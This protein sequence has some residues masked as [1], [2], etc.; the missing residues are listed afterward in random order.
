[1]TNKEISRALKLIAAL[2]ELHNENPFKLKSFTNAAFNVDRAGDTLAGKP[3]EE[4][5]LIPGIG[6]SIALQIIELLETGSTEDLRNYAAITPTGVIEMLGVKGIGPKKVATIWRELGIESPG[7]LLYA[8]YENRL[9][10]LK[11]FGTKTQ[12][13]IRTALEYRLA[14]QGKLHFAEAEIVANE[15]INLLNILDENLSISFT[16]EL[17]RYMEVIENL[18]LLIVSNPKYVE[19]LLEK[20]EQVQIESVLEE[21]ILIKMADKYSVCLICCEEDQYEREQL[22]RTGPAEHL[23]ELDI[24]PEEPIGS[25]KVFY[26]D[27]GFPFILP[28]LRDLPMETSSKIDITQLVQWNSIRGILHNHSTY[29]DGI[30]SLEEMAIACRDL[31]MEY[32]GICDHSKSAFYAGGL[33][34]E[35]VLQQHAEIE[36]LNAQLAPFKILKGIESDILSDGSLDYPDEILE[37]FDLVVASVHSILNMDIDRATKRLITAIENPYTTILGHPTGRLLLSR[38]G[39]PIDYKKVIDA[40]A[41]NDVIMELNAHPYRLD[42]DWRWIP[43]CMEK[44]VQISINPDAHKKEG[45]SDMH[46]GVY[47]A[48]KGG[49]TNDFLFNGKPLNEMITYLNNF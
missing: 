8:C 35:K 19:S 1:M 14:N 48:R 39:Y 9:V 10:D 38:K 21:S 6:K 32:L 44:G 37:T 23:D 31:G 46:Y 2:G 29:S 28:E 25:E 12:E 36:K 24:D 40:C 3:L 41:A 4:L 42:I 27:R 16:G 49:L 22:L 45:Y 7:E 18:E 15:L 30:H 13:T 5:I 47:V 43:Y 20:C 17:R 11:G 33:S 34:I 26:E